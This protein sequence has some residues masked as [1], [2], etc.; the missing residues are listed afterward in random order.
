M[1]ERII[2]GISDEYTVQWVAVRILEMSKGDA[3]C[4]IVDLLDGTNPTEI[5]RD[6][7][8]VA[9]TEWLDDLRYDY[10]EHKDECVAEENRQSGVQQ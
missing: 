10:Q 3:E 8:H 5:I 4:V 2:K 7:L 6:I 9:N 1:K